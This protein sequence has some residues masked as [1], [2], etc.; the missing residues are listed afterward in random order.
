[1][2]IQV[3]A[4]YRTIN[5][6]IIT[7]EATKLIEFLEKVFGAAEVKE[8]HTLDT[9]GLLLHSEVR[10]GDSV[11][12]VADTKEGWPFT[13]SL[14]QI[15]VEDV[16]KTLEHAENLGA[17]IVTQPTNMYGDIFSR[18]V[19]PWGNGWWVYQHLGEFTWDEN[20]NADNDAT[21]NT[22]SSELTYIRDTLL[23]MMSHLSRK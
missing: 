12:M 9:D 23:E 19:D 1:M 22:E 17:R 16:A 3:P 14:L 13:P 10:I 20:P 6:F 15:Y 7:K 5:S 2:S 18:M 21:W 4:G 8:A 11:V